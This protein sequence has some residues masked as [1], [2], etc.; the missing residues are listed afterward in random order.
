MTI[1]QWFYYATNVE[2]SLQILVQLQLPVTAK[3]LAGGTDLHLS[4][5][6]ERYSPI[7]AIVDIMNTPEPNL[8]EHHQQEIFLRAAV[9]HQMRTTSSPAKQDSHEVVKV[10]GLI[11]ELHLRSVLLFGKPLPHP[12]CVVF[13]NNKIIL[14]ERSINGKM[15]SV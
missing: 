7:K 10:S 13:D 14:L 11:Q 6:Q 1:C 5:Q 3:I 15:V 12:C 4:F 8:V 9:P 2:V